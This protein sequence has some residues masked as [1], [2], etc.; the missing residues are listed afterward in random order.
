MFGEIKKLS[1]LWYI[2]YVFGI[3][4]TELRVCNRCLL[5]VAWFY[6]VLGNDVLNVKCAHCTYQRGENLKPR[7]KVGYLKK[8]SNLVTLVRFRKFYGRFLI[9]SGPDFFELYI[10]LVKFDNSLGRFSPRNIFNEGLLKV[11]ATIL[12]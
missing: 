5:L 1:K 9:P 2:R 12:N 10:I 3:F 6:S 4:G 7:P 8:V 11:L